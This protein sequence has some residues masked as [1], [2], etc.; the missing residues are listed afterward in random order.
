MPTTYK[1]KEED[2]EGNSYLYHSSADIVAF[3]SSKIPNFDADNT[4]TAIEALNLKT[5]AKANT[6]TLITT[7]KASAFE[8][9]SSPYTQTIRV[10]GIKESDNPIAGVIFDDNIT[11]AVLQQDGWSYISRITCADDTITVYC[12]GDKPNIDLPIQL[13]IVR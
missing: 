12:F 3:D 4:Q 11:V 1:V 10:D 5:E 7:I 9:D 8:G 13:K 6:I 2:N